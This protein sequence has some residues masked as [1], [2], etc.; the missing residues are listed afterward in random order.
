MDIDNGNDDTNDSNNRENDNSNVNT[1]EN[2]NQGDVDITTTTDRLQRVQQSQGISEEEPMMDQE[3]NSRANLSEQTATTKS[4]AP[5]PN[6]SQQ[7]DIV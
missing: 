6:L 1:N 5:Q 2:I 3:E 4:G 7:D